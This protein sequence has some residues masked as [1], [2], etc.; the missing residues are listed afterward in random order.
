MKRE[1]DIITKLTRQTHDLKRDSL[2]RVRMLDQYNRIA[3]SSKNLLQIS[4]ADK[5]LK[6]I[7][8]NQIQR[9][10]KIEQ[11]KKELA[12]VLRY[13][14]IDPSISSDA[15]Y[16]FSDENSR[17]IAEAFMRKQKSVTIK[18]KVAT[19]SYA[20]IIRRYRIDLTT[21]SIT[22]PDLQGIYKRLVKI[23]TPEEDDNVGEDLRRPSLPQGWI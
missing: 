10:K 4:K 20:G 14:F 21:N 18:H 22:S 6:K 13:G 12:Q 23:H 15:V 11:L 9:T 2:A 19:G 3:R 1:T 16:A 7:I 17:I 8:T 5:Q